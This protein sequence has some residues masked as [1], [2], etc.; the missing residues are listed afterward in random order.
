MI[1]KLSALLAATLLLAACVSTHMEQYVGRDI[2]DV[3]VDS[4]E[5][6]NVFDMGDGRRAFQFYW[7]GGTIAVP[8]KTTTTGSV[9]GNTVYLDSTTYPGGVVH[10]PGCLITYFARHDEANNAWIVSEISYPERLVC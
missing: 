2:R 8:Q 5:P 3:M 9:V 6:V 7:G 4:G 10:N 1:R